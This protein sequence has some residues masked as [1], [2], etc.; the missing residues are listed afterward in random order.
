MIKIIAIGNSFSQDA[1]YYLHQIAEA[2]KVEI[3]A[4][5]LFI[6]GCNLKRHWYNISN[7]MQDYYY[8]ENGK[9]TGR[10]VS[11]TQALSMDDWNYV[12]TQQASHDSGIAETYHPYLEQIA[13]YVKKTAPQAELLLHET[14][15][16]E[17]DC[18]HDQFCRYEKNQ[19]IMYDKLSHA[20]KSAAEQLSLRLIPCGDVVQKLRAKE[21]FR[22]GH[23]GMSLCRDGFHM[24]LIY[25]RYLLSA[26]WYRFLTG[27]SV[28]KNTY[29]PHTELAPNA[30]CD[31]KVL[32]VIK[33]AVDEMIN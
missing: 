33:S 14:W 32:D 26:V 30:V 6:G 21:P 10:T 20:Y 5:N 1:T 3:K 28:S 19:Q 8:E 25:G 17:N 22:Y 31:G 18:L 27:N 4:V 13:A 29:V 24:N 12:V 2:D 11:V 23:G 15:A 9:Y 16:Y 7:D